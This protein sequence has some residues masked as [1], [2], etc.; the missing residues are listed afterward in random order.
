MPARAS[1]IPSHPER[2][3]L[4]ALHERGELKRTQLQYAGVT[5]NK[6]IA[7]GWIEAATPGT[8]RI[9]AAGIAAMT[10]KILSKT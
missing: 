2:I 1:H 9:T 3:I 10:A 7:K 4:Q 8:Y 6:V 5:I